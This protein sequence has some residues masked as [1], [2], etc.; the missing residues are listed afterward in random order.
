[1]TRKPAKKPK[2]TLI[3]IILF[4]LLKALV[5]A[6]KT[7][8]PIILILPKSSFFYTSDANIFFHLVENVLSPTD[9]AVKIG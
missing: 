5:P 8:L 9:W 2:K 1:M 4:F 6:K 7:L 3:P